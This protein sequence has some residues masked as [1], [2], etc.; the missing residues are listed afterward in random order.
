MT[1]GDAYKAILQ[2]W[3]STWHTLVGGTQA[4]PTIPY[5]VDNRKLQQPATR[6]ASV[7]IVNVGSD[8]A[9]MGAPG[10][11]RFE[12]LGFID[13]RLFGPRDQGRGQLDALAEHV[14]TLYES[15]RLGAIGE[16]RGLV[17]YAMDT[18]EIR[19]DPE[20]P[21]LWCLLCRIPFYYH[22]RR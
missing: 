20:F 5:A 3:I 8:Q 22:H 14:R 10:F 1:P 6:F 18:T 13:V 11:R 9:T 15:T 17:T 12:R 19:N 16:D 21:D 7:E 4:A 2:R